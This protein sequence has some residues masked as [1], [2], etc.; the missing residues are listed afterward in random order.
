MRGIYKTESG[1]S[2]T[3][4]YPDRLI[5]YGTRDCSFWTDNFAHLRYFSG[6]PICP[7]CHIP[8]MQTT[9]RVW[10]DGAKEFQTMHPRY[11]EFLNYIKERCLKSSHGTGDLLRL[12]DA[13]TKG[14]LLL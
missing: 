1:K 10:F 2:T 6:I 8:G 14:A 7:T 9:A 11:V 4:D 12:Y 13:F 3:H 5:W